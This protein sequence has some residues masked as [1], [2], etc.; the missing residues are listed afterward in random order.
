MIQSKIIQHVKK[1]NLNS[2]G[3]R[4]S[5]D[6]S[7]EMTQVL[8]LSNTDFN[9]YVIKILWKV[10]ANTLRMRKDRKHQQINRRYKE[11]PNGNFRTKNKI[12]FLKFTG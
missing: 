3:K 6:A 2:H 7:A 10:R 5:T 1:Q 9:A 12:N 4:Q 8:E 11:K